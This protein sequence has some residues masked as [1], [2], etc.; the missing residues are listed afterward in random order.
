MAKIFKLTSVLTGLVAFFMMFLPQVVVNF[1]SGAETIGFKALTGGTYGPIGT[2]FNGVGAGLAGY[3][4][5]GV[6]ALLVL[7]TAFVGFFK[8]HEVLDYIVLGI[9]VICMI[10]GIILIFLI[11]KNFSDVNGGIDTSMAFGMI[12]A[13]VAAIISGLTAV[14]SLVLDIAQ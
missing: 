9:A 2:E 5:V 13:G 6:A 11:R 10:I 1:T 12:I 7:A 3:I 14:L 4:L 8:E